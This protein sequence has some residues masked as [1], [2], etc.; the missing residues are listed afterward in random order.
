MKVALS[1]GHHPSAQGC[2]SAD[3]SY[4]E[5]S[6]WKVHLPILKAKLER[7]GHTAVITNR[8]DGGGASP[9]YAAIACNDVSA[10]LAIE[11]H[12]NSASPTATGTESFCWYSSVKG[13]LAAQLINDAMVG[14]L[15]LTNRGIKMVS[16]SS[17][18]AYSYFQKTKMPAV[19]V[20]PSFAASNAT[21]CSRL[22]SRIEPL[23][24]AIAVAIDKFSKSV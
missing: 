3:G 23:C 22:V 14:V 17:D 4:T 18:N 9:S 1:I 12:F 5:Y 16:K 2:K 6:F 24:D 20:E 11:F 21:D 8:A 19:L 10:D 15:G 13:K 7:F